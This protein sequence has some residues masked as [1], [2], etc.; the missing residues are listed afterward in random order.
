[1]FDVF[2]REINAA[3]IAVPTKIAPSMKK[4][5]RNREHRGELLLKKNTHQIHGLYNKQTKASH[6]FFR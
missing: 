2:K 6:G 3:A 4:N 5:T 1:M